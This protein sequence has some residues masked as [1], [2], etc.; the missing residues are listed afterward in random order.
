M[1]VDFFD[2]F[3]D[4]ADD[5][6]NESEAA[7]RRCA[8]AFLVHGLPRPWVEQRVDDLKRAVD[9]FVS[10]RRPAATLAAQKRVALARAADASRLPPS[11]KYRA[12]RRNLRRGEA[13]PAWAAFDCGRRRR[14]NAWR[15]EHA[16]RAILET[17][18]YLALHGDLDAVLDPGCAVILAERAPRCKLLLLAGVGHHAYLQEPGEWCALV[19]RFLGGEERWR[20]GGE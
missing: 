11:S 17:P 3:D 6:S 1:S 5:G 15:S 13:T 4:W 2:V 14:S 7:R 12:R 18:R 19:S 16:T 20:R 8:A 10:E 9:A